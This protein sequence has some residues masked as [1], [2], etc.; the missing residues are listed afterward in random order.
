V[1]VGA[2]QASGVSAAHEDML[3]GAFVRRGGVEG[4]PALWCVPALG[5]SGD[6]FAPLFATRLGGLFELWAPDLPGVGA[7]PVAAD[8]VD[9]GG[10]ADWLVRTIAHA[11]PDAPLGLVGHSLG[12]AVAVRVAR[13]LA[14]RVVGVFSIEGNLTE[15]DAYFSGLAASFDDPELF[16][17][18]LVARVG[19]LADRAAG[20]ARV[21][22]LRYQASLSGASAEM[23]WRLARSAK[24]ARGGDALGA[25][26]RALE[27]PSLYHWSPRNTPLPTQAYLRAHRIRNVAFDGGHWPMIEQPHETASQIASFF[28]PLF[29]QARVVG[30]D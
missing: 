23:L 5:D 16:K 22:L 7:T 9:L 14:G 20:R 30:H 6:S 10:L 2:A 1:A 11:S 21:P 3:G 17:Q 18:E 8:V 27:V 29:E 26:Y 25:E 24:A 19:T 28:E 13:R 12:A 15:A 4:G